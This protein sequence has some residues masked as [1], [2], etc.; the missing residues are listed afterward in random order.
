M[1]QRGKKR[2]YIALYV[3]G[4]LCLGAVSVADYIATEIHKVSYIALDLMVMG[5]V[6]FAYLMRQQA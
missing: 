5:T 2:H 4:M 1:A 6:S 3:I